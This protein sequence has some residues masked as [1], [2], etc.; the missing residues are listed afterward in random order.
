M[1]VESQQSSS[2]SFQP[3]LSV[4]LKKFILSA[5]GPSPFD[6]YDQTVVVVLEYVGT[7][8]NICENEL[9]C[10]V[11]FFI[12]PELPVGQKLILDCPEVS[13]DPSMS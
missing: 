11:V 7:G 9:I 8:G 10:H 2:L 4:L 12:C 5:K 1:T 6:R 3:L 13:I